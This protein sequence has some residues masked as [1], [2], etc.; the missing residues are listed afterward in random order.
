[1]TRPE[2]KEDWLKDYSPR[3]YCCGYPAVMEG[4]MDGPG[5]WRCKGCEQSC[6]PLFLRKGYGNSDYPYKTGICD[7]HGGIKRDYRCDD[8]SLLENVERGRNE[9]TP[10]YKR[11]MQEAYQKGCSEECQRFREI[12]EEAIDGMKISL[13]DA[14]YQPNSPKFGVGKKYIAEVNHRNKV[15]DKAKQKILSKLETNG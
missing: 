15:L 6:Q 7:K 9:A 14:A 10:E 3:S 1:M 4:V 12:V 2:E 11:D 5:W 8:C 13:L